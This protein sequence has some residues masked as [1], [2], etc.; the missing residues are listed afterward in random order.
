MLVK[1]ILLSIIFLT[2]AALGFGVRML[3]AQDFSDVVVQR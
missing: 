3:F 2:I 1:L